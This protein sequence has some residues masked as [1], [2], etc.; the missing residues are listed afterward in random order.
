MPILYDAVVA[1]LCCAGIVATFIALFMPRSKGNT[2][3]AGII[4][5]EDAADIAKCAVSLKLMFNDVIVVTTLDLNGVIDG[6]RV[7][8]PEEFENYVTG[9]H[10]N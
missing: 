2:K 3:V 10:Q 8:T 7:L 6:V 4:V 9:N 1:F 5:S